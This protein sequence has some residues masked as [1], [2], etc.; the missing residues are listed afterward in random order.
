MENS[1]MFVKESKADLV[2]STA[3]KSKGREWNCVKLENDFLYRESKNYSPEESNLLYVA[4]TRAQHVLDITE[5]E[6]IQELL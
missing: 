1:A 3:H 5:C 6:A 4:A 2:L